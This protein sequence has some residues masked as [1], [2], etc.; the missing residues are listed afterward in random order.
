[1]LLLFFKLKGSFFEK[2]IVW[3]YSD[4]T[5]LE[6]VRICMVKKPFCLPHIVFLVWANVCNKLSHEIRSTRMS[7]IVTGSRMPKLIRFNTKYVLVLEK[8]ELFVRKKFKYNSSDFLSLQI[9]PDMV[10]SR[11]GRVWNA[12]SLHLEYECNLKDYIWENYILILLKTRSRK[13]VQQKALL[14]L[15]GIKERSLLYLKLSFL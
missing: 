14:C 10:S 8:I 6:T 11:V 2:E 9:A 1:M 13:E 15:L 3:K 4:L 7:D 12:A 5:V